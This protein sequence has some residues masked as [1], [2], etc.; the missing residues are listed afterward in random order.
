MPVGRAFVNLGSGQ[1]R[2]TDVVR[3]SYTL[4]V[5]QYQADP[6]LWLVAEEPI[7][8]ASAPI[9]NLAVQLS[10]AVDIPVSLSYEAG[11]QE[12][13]TI[14][15]ILRPQHSVENARQLFIGPMVKPPGRQPNSVLVEGTPLTDPSSQPRI[16]TNVIPDKY[17]L[18]VQANG[19]SGY[20]AS[21][22]LGDVDVLHSEFPISGS[23]PG[24]L[25]VTIRGDSATVQGQVTFQG[26][27]AQG[28]QIYLIP[29]DGAGTKFGFGDQDGHYEIKGVPP[30]D[31]RIH[32]WTMP[33]TDKEILAGSG[34]TLTLQPGDQQTVALEATAVEQR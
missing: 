21:A 19:G 24:E 31:Y 10:G 17:K 6:P 3:G 16:L 34:E 27:P 8:I 26:Q 29:T 33:P 25:H 7:T 1:F 5:E 18:A 20:V 9:R 14:F 4:R 23:S 28:A 15:L 13:G 32:A 30:G 11:A 2:L 22:K 12:D